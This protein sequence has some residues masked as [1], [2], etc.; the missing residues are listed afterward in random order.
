MTWTGIALVWAHTHTHTCW[1]SPRAG[2]VCG[3]QEAGADSFPKWWACQFSF[4]IRRGVRSEAAHGALW[5]PPAPSVSWHLGHV[6]SS[7]NPCL[8]SLSWL[9]VLLSFCFWNLCGY[10]WG[11]CNYLNRLSNQGDADLAD[12]GFVVNVKWESPT[13]GKRVGVRSGWAWHWRM[14][15]VWAQTS[16]PQTLGEESCSGSSE[17]VFAQSAFF[18]ISA[19]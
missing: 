12:K 9:V 8:L 4:P 15:D 13:E 3:A 1:C 6:P 10:C 11:L 5:S 14:G 16:G 17:P 18:A 2:P 7:L 19:V